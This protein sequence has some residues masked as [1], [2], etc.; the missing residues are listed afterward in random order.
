MPPRPSRCWPPGAEAEPGIP[1]CQQDRACL[2]GDRRRP[3]PIDRVAADLPFKCRQAPWARD[4][5]EGHRQPRPGQCGGVQ[6]SARY[7]ARPDRGADLGIITPLTAY[8]LVPLGDNTFPKRGARRNSKPGP[9]PT[10][11]TQASQPCPRPV[12]CSRRARQRPAELGAS[13]AAARGEPAAR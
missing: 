8:G 7:R 10:R 13:C 6:T 3:M 4:A 5:P 9:D 2:P 12:R 11:L 1:Q